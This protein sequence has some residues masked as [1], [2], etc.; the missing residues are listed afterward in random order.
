MTGNLRAS[1]VRLSLA[2][3]LLAGVS[4]CGG[5]EEYT[6]P[7]EACVRDVS[8]GELGALLP[9]GAELRE[10][11][12]VSDK[13]FSC[14]VYVDDL[15]QLAFT[16]HSGQRK[17][18][19]LAYAKSGRLGNFGRFRASD[20]S[21]NAVVSHTRSVVMAPCPKAGENY[22]LNLELPNTEGDHS[23]D[24]ERFVRSYL[25]TGLAAMGC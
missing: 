19:V 25:P 12:S 18:D 5:V 9:S 14:Q 2:A 6:V 15:M 4:A 20:V 23:D 24:I 22:I 13:S 7:S 10:K 16:E 17:F 11:R 8:K 3:L 21:D 1:A